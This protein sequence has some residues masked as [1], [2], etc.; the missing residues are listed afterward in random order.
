MLLAAVEAQAGEFRYR[1]HLDGKPE[2]EPV[3]WSER[4]LERRAR[5]G[6]QTDS[7]DLEIS[8]RYIEQIEAAGL[9]I[10]TR[11]HWLNTVVV[12]GEEGQAVADSVFAGLHFVH[13]VDLLTT[14]QKASAPIH[15]LQ[16]PPI[17]KAADEDC[18]SP[19]RQVNAYE[20]LYEAGHRG[21]G[22]LVVIVDVGFP[23]V[24]KWDWLNR[25]VVGVRDMYTPLSGTS[26]V[27]T[28]HRHGTCCLSIMASPEE[29]GICGV[30]QEADYYLI[31]T[32]TDD[33][34]TELEED[35]WVAGIEL[36]D[37]LGA[38]VVS[39]SLGYY[40]FDTEENNHR[41][42]EFCR[43]MAFISRGA[44]VACQKGMLV[45]NAAGNERTN[46]WGRLI[47]PADVE[48]V[49]TVGGV[50]PDGTLAFFS[51]PGFMTPYVKPDVVGRGTHCYVVTDLGD[52]NSSGQGTSYATPLIAGLCTSLWSAV[53]ELS[54]AQIRQVVR[55]SASQYNQPD[56]LLGCG[57]PDFGVA[58]AKARVLLGEVG[59]DEVKAETPQRGT[60]LFNLQGQR[61]ANRPRQGI[62]IENGRLKFHR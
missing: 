41:Y 25:Q 27:Y 30:A 45:C 49:L 40:Y 18:T 37:S 11:S 50:N 13:R 6:I 42:D 4:A 56:S 10:V 62:F 12:M 60:G 24:D 35:M 7:L 31:R 22:M 39:S 14:Q 58:L 28:S 61:C 21:G 34:E 15:P 57:I 5:Y 17:S 48:E 44:R 19:L 23:N 1:L 59:I 2:S 8:P 55:E 53:P 46:D 52:V 47:F 3:K 20:P 36:A 51:S 29:H 16:S 54:A 38:D 26:K 33:S 32:E 43:D 9:T